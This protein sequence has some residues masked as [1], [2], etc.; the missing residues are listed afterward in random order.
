MRGKTQ[1]LGGKIAK[2]SVGLRYLT[3]MVLYDSTEH[4]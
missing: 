3:L 4:E 1:E 2:I